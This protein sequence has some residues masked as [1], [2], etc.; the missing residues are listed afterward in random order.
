[1]TFAAPK[2]GSGDKPSLALSLPP[3]AA[4]TTITPPQQEEEEE[5]ESI[6]SAFIPP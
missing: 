2:V 4:A 6:Y 3:A 5:E 1:M